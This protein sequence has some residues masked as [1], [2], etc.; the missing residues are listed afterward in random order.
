LEA[1]V[2]LKKNKL[3]TWH[4]YAR[5]ASLGNLGFCTTW[6]VDHKHNDH[7]EWIEVVE[8]DLHMQNLTEPF[9]GKRIV[10]ISDLHCSRTVSAKYLRHCIDR[11]NLLNADIV[12]LTGDYVTHDLYGKFRKKVTSLIGKIKTNH[13][14]YACLGNHDYGV[15]SM[16]GSWRDDLVH[17]LTNNMTSQGVKLLRNDSAE[18]QIDGQS[19]WMVGLGDLWVNDF[20]PDKAFDQV[21]EDDPVIALMHNPNGAMHLKA[22]PVDAVMSG[23]THGVNTRFAPAPGWKLNKRDFLSGMY[24]LGNKKLYVNRGLGRLGRCFFNARPEITVFTLR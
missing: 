18:L 21:P 12:V 10:Q 6:A 11:I 5:G 7:K 1:W 14:T 23:H 8:V 22:Y 15:G 13:G 24:E 2:I 16:I 19:I 4:R 20:D 17:E 9:H 3:K